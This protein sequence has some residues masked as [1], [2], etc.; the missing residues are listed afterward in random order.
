MPEQTPARTSHAFNTPD[1]LAR[2]VARRFAATSLSLAALLVCADA[3]RAQQGQTTPPQQPSSSSS[4]DAKVRARRAS[5]S[6]T[7][8][9]KNAQTKTDAA[10]GAAVPGEKAQTDAA[11]SAASPAKEAKESQEVKEDA[12]QASKASVK[13]GASLVSAD[14]SALKETTAVADVEDLKAQLKAAKS[15]TERARLHRALVGRLVTSESKAQAVE[16]LRALI[17]DER[18]DPAGLYNVG[19]ALARLDESRAAAE[20]YRKAITQRRGHYSRAQNNLGVVLL[21]LGLWDEAQEALAAALRQESGLYAEAHYNM[22]RL[23]ALRGEAG[24]AI[25]SW[26]HALM[27]QP[28][29]ADAAVALARALAE[30]GDPARGLA[31][32]DAFDQRAARNGRQSPREI[33]IARGE[34]IAVSNL[35]TEAKAGGRLS[36]SSAGEA[37]RGSANSLHALVVDR[38][39]Y[40]LLQR[41]RAAREAGRNEDAVGLYRRVI[42]NRGGY[43]PPA[44]LELGYALSGLKRHEEAVESFLPVAAKEGARYPIAF[45]HLGRLYETLGQL[46]RAGEAFTRAASFY[47]QQNPQF[48]VDISRVREKEGNMGEALAAMESYV[49]V[50]ERLSGSAPDWAQQRVE[51]L[52]EKN[53]AAQK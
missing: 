34:I 3:L 35:S 32:L 4:T 12:P 43:F 26:S 17:E 38:Q 16:E 21:R 14:A 2:R 37:A 8:G 29:H 25:N 44:N 1:N 50:S 39:T 28:D 53:G 40:D 51:K 6:K 9:A 11:R 30:D 36:S 49:R 27:Q 42:Q 33:A 24:L 13:D 45:Y 20:A 46:P 18:F 41:A 52:R 19:N 22:G 10:E 5:A 47:G 31:I 48:Y 7:P 15:N 23:H